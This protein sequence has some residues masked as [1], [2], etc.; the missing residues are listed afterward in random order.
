MASPDQVPDR[1]DAILTLLKS[2][3]K[4]ITTC[5]RLVVEA[6][7]GAGGHRTAEEVSAYVQAEAPDIHLASVYRNL[8]ELEK[9]RVVSHVHLGHG[10][11]VYH[12]AADDHGHLV[13]RHCGMVT[14]APRDVFAGLARTL[15]GRY[16]FW[17]DGQHFAV[18]GLCE[19]CAADV[20]TRAPASTSTS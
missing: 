4:R 10:P 7:V 14:E 18:H 9:L 19:V 11:A 5:R 12:L 1:V 20:P 3:G 17:V 15:R 8:D 13:C 16:G 2:E 6:L